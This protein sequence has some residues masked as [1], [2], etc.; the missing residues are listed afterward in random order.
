MV[1]VCKSFPYFWAES[2][3]CRFLMPKI[4]VFF[5]ICIYDQKANNGKLMGDNIEGLICVWNLHCLF[6]QNFRIDTCMF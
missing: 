4:V 5:K 2:V 3:I 1:T 6:L